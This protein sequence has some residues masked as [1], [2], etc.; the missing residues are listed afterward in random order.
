M[1]LEINIFNEAFRGTEYSMNHM[2]T[3]DLCTASSKYG[4][5]PGKNF[6]LRP[7]LTS[8]DPEDATKHCPDLHI[9][10]AQSYLEIGLIHEGTRSAILATSQYLI[11]GGRANYLR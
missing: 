1:T 11:E 10:L 9:M 3:K 7:L 6:A 8:L 4:G 2:R 5:D